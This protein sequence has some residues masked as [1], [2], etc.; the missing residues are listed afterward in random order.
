MCVFVCRIRL[1]LFTLYVFWVTVDGFPHEVSD[2]S[3]S[4][5]YL[6]KVQTLCSGPTLSSRV[7]DLYYVFMYIYIF[8]RYMRVCCI[9]VIYIY[10][11]Y[12]LSFNPTNT[13]CYFLGKDMGF[14]WPIGSIFPFNYISSCQN[15][16]SLLHAIHS[17][18]LTILTEFVSI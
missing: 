3:A 5:I 6:F 17:S 4:W 1:L 12:I 13:G 9:F 10:I 15:K 7:L 8:P 2:Y 16:K 18:T 11:L 14:F